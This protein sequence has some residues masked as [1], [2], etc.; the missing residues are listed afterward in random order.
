[1]K[2]ITIKVND[3]AT[4]EKVVSLLKEHAP[5]M[6][7]EEFSMVKYLT[8]IQTGVDY[9]CYFLA[10]AHEERLNAL[11][12]IWEWKEKNDGAFGWGEVMNGCIQKY[13]ISYECADEK[14]EIGFLRSY[15]NT[16]EIPYFSTQEIAQR[17]LKELEAEYKVVFN[18]E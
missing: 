14:F 17:A 12:K 16:T 18:V 8:D 15:V 5:E 10:K 3:E 13:F 7:G 9:D 11:L 1:M 4:E 6:L 2:T